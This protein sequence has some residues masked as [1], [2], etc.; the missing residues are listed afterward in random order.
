MVSLLRLLWRGPL[1]FVTWMARRHGPVARVGL[2]SG[3][4]QVF[5]VSCP[6]LIRQVLVTEA[7]AFVKDRGLDAT[8]P[9]LGNGLL[10]SEG[11]FHLR[12]RRLAQPAFHRQRIPG[13]A[14]TM[15]GCTLERASAWR[16][17][18]RVDLAQEMMSLT[19]DVVARTLFGADIGQDM[20]ALSE[21]LNY[22]T[23]QFTAPRIAFLPILHRLPLPSTLRF[24][25]Y[26]SQLKA[27]I[28]AIIQ[29]RRGN[30]KGDRGDLLSMLLAA[31]EQETMTDLQLRDECLTLFLAG[32]ETTANAL[33]WTLYLLDQHP[34]VAERLRAELDEVVGKRAV[35]LDDVPK[36]ELADKV[37]RES[38]RLYPPAW[39]LGRRA[40]RRVQLG[41]FVIPEGA[42]VVTS[43][44]VMHRSPTYFPEPERFRPERWTSE[45][46]ASL[47]RFAYFPFGGGTRICIA[48]AFA[49]TETILVL[50][51]L[52]RDWSFRCQPGRPV[53]PQ[54]HITLRPRGGLWGQWVRR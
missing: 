35:S 15:V 50:A 33:T 54:P 1:D 53:V 28:D 27:T 16:H 18:Q 8:R 7:D 29:G 51:T 32:H 31:Q 42:T 10:T 38:W 14:E 26:A 40:I 5:F 13:Y 3:R 36:L 39:T 12:Q 52:L 11:E 49:R 17:L 21:A 45:F 23:A 30:P 46:I 34:N 20:G 2:G 41:G 19:L 44:W 25:A 43:Q 24:R 22:C 37:V 4:F 47:P 48:E 6:D 9:L